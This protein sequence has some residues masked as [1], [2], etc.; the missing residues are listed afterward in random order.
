MENTVSPELL[1]RLHEVFPL[2]PEH[3]YKAHR[4]CL[5]KKRYTKYEAI[6]VASQ[7]RLVQYVPLVPLEVYECFYCHG[8][9]IGHA[10]LH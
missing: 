8:W 6:Q 2:L 3:E 4:S 9:H 10:R 7:M 5:H 1:R